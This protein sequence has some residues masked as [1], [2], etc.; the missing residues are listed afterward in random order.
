MRRWYS[1]RL[2]TPIQNPPTHRGNLTLKFFTFL[3][4]PRLVLEN[5]VTVVIYAQNGTKREKNDSLDT[6]LV[7]M[8]LRTQRGGE[9]DLM[10]HFWK[11][12]MYDRSRLLAQTLLCS[13]RCAQHGCAY[14]ALCPLPLRSDR[15]L[16]RVDHRAQGE[17]QAMQIY[18]TLSG[19]RK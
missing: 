8:D 11:Q 14:S 7:W 18:P 9:G 3:E 10:Y 16:V 17:E 15:R 4:I 6:Q 2:E 12:Y 1:I 5:Q 13:L 19:R